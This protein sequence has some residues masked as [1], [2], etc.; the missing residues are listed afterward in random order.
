MCRPAG[1]TEQTSRRFQ[2]CDRKQSFLTAHIDDF[3]SNLLS[4]FL[5]TN[6]GHGEGCQ[7]KEDRAEDPEPAVA[8]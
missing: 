3:W 5:H 2:T 6:A 8:G 1:I 7:P 4:G